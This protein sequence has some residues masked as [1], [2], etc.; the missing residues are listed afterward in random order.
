MRARFALAFPP[1][2]WRRFHVG[3]IS[4]VH[5]GRESPKGRIP[6]FAFGTSA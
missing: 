4:E 3:V 6:P 1:Y 5:V 2:A